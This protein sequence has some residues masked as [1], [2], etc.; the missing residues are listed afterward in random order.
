MENEHK[1]IVSSRRRLP[2]VWIIPLV[3][4][5]VGVGMVINHYRTQGPEITITFK[6]AEGLEAGKT[7]IKALSVDIGIVESVTLNPDLNGVTLT[8]QLD[9]EATHLLRDDTKFWVVRPRIGAAGITGFGTLLS[10]AYIELLPGQGKKILKR[11]RT[12]QGLDNV[13]ITHTDE[14]GLNITLLSDEAVS[15]SAGDPVLYHGYNVGTIDSTKLDAETQKID[16][17]IFIKSPYDRLVTS[18]SRFW[19]ASG[20]SFQ[21]TAAGVSL[22]TGSLATLIRG[23][24]TFDLPKGANPGTAVENHAEFKLYPDAGSINKNPYQ[25]YEEY[26]LLFDTSVSGLVAGAPVLYRGVRAGTVIDVGFGIIGVDLARTKG[27]AASVPVLIHIEPGRW[28]GVDTEEAKTKAFTD[29]DKSINQGLRATIKLG[30]LLTGARVISIDFYEDVEP[31][32]MAKVGKFNTFPTITT[33]LEGIE[34]KVADL[35]DKLNELPL[36]TVLNDI[37]VTL[38]QVTHTLAAANKTVNGLNTIL[39]NKDTQQMPESINT[40]LDELRLAL[41]G[42]SPDSALYQVLSDSIEQLNTTL[43]NIESLTYTIGTKPNSLI[44]SKPKQQDLQP[45]A[46]TK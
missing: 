11:E 20:I 16:L 19:N 7:K 40:T 5:V 2:A 43:R 17:K 30:N 33:G 15:V 23:G 37:D 18:N 6:T 28:L 12:F 14:S 45:E 38:K 31:A 34:V 22:R 24:V 8:A 42:L 35:L 46:V 25:Y 1:A 3:A 39:E 26:L 41:K 32:T 29:I 44:F 9:R 36:E 10:G 27:R 21:A 13:P 4:L